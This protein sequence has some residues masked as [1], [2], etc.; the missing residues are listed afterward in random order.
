LDLADIHEA[1]HVTGSTAAFQGNVYAAGGAYVSGTLV[2]AGT[3]TLQGVTATTISAGNLQV[4]GNI[5]LQGNLDSDVDVAKT[6]FGSVT[7]AITLGGGGLVV[8]A[9]DLKVGGNDIQASDGTTALTLSSANVTVAGDLTVTGNNI[10][11]SGGTT[12]LTLSDADVSVAGD[13]T[14]LGGKITLT[15]GATI[16]SE[17]NGKLILTEDLVEL[18]GDLKVGGNDIQASDG[19][20]NITM[21]SNTLTEIKGDLQVSGNDIKSAGGFTA[22]TLDNANVIVA[23]DLTVNGTTTAINTNNLEIKDSVVGL[24]FASGTVQQSA[25]DRGWIGGLAG[26]DNVAFFYDDSATE[27]VVSTTTNSATGSLPIPIGS[28]S[29]FHAAQ[30]SGSI[31][32]AQ[33]GLSGSLTQLVDGTSY[34]VAGSGITIAS[35]SN[36]QVTI[37]NSGMSQVSKGYLAGNST[38]ISASNGI[39][40]FGPAGANIGTLSSAD[41]EKLDVFLNGIFMAFGYDISTITQTTFTLDLT[42]INSLTADDIISIVLRGTI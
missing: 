26:G 36:G 4:S 24:G 23:G 2:V 41:D 27:F 37:S 14:V 17:T 38:H 11:A 39:V 1:L 10:K 34:I 30:I 13:L 22:I 8:T 19:N 16:D 32:K 6:L 25:G 42:I 20:V 3:S 29:N 15:N 21:T 7:N 12:S 33:Y 31:V 28:Y 9:G 40:T 5:T 35:S 18:S